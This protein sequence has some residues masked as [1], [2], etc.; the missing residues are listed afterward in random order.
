M[1][2]R[3]ADKFYAQEHA[4]PG[5]Y[6][7]W[8]ILADKPIPLINREDI[9]AAEKFLVKADRQLDIGPFSCDM[10]EKYVLFIAF[11][12]VMTDEEILSLVGEL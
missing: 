5:V 2:T 9:K 7:I 3:I 8:A 6:V 11:C 4:F 12:M 10:W 1:S